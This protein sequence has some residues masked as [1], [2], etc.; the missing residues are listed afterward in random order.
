MS[1]PPQYP[2]QLP[3]QQQSPARNRNRGRLRKHLKGLAAIAV[4]VI[5]GLM[6]LSGCRVVAV[7]SASPTP[8]PSHSQEWQEGY[9]AGLNMYQ[10]TDYMGTLPD[11]N[12]QNIQLV[13][14]CDQSAVG[15]EPNLPDLTQWLDGYD[16]GCYGA[17]S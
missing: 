3:H 2:T 15:D 7:G 9:Q 5:G 14:F 8:Q 12:P 6:V 11:K 13:N 1:T 16:A 4:L 17:A 10:Q